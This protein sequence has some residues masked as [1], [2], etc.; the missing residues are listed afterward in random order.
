MLIPVL[1]LEFLFVVYCVRLPDTRLRIDD[2]AHQASRAAS[3]ERDPTAAASQARTT[4]AAALDEA[5]ISCQ[6]FTVHTRGSLKP[7][8]TVTVTLS[9]TVGLHDLTLLQ[10]PGT[11]AVKAQSAAQVDLH[12]GA[13]PS[14]ASAVSAEPG[15]EAP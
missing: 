10:V 4:A 14:H 6:S 3:Q 8:S 2:A 12:R 7:G 5:G 1:L 11:T 13:S 9:C 15:R